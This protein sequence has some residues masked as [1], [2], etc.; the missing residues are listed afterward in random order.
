MVYTGSNDWLLLV[1]VALR[2]LSS[3]TGSASGSAA[4]SHDIGALSPTK[5][6]KPSVRFSDRGQTRTIPRRPAGVGRAGSVSGSSSHGVLFDDEGQPT[7]L[8][9]QL[10]ESLARHLSA[11]LPPKGGLVM[12]PAK[13]ATFYERYF[14]DPEPI[15]RI[16]ALFRADHDAAYAGLEKVYEVLGCEYH[17]VRDSSTPKSRPKLPAL[18][19]AGY[20]EFMTI[21]LLAFPDEEFRRLQRATSDI[22]ILTNP[23]PS[24]G[25]VG[26][27]P[28][29]LI[30]SLFPARHDVEAKK[31]YESTLAELS[32]CLL[33][34]AAPT[35]TQEPRRP[36]ITP[37]DPRRYVPEHIREEPKRAP[38]DSSRGTRH[39][40]S[41]SGPPS[42]EQQSRPSTNGTTFA[43]D[44]AF[45]NDGPPRS[46]PATPFP[47]SGHNAPQQLGDLV[48]SKDKTKA[49]NRPSLAIPPLAA[50]LMSFPALE[51]GSTTSSPTASRN[52]SPDVSRHGLP[53]AHPPPPPPL[54]SALVNRTQVTGLKEN[55][56]D[57]A[58]TAEVQRHRNNPSTLP[59][60]D[61]GPTWEEKLSRGGASSA[62]T[63]SSSS[64]TQ[65]R[66]SGY[67]LPSSSPASAGT[68]SRS[69]KRRDSIKS[70][71]KDR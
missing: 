47:A 64:H 22:P 54:K 46:A 71:R 11:E 13:M 18:T 31:A 26:Q 66:K 17:L 63:S 55:S 12:T 4:N 42:G 16:A 57:A 23:I 3:P 37:F 45:S 41:Y 6:P 5:P 60:Q 34:K 24:P 21:A 25:D 8:C 61:R 39:S 53:S 65:S 36:S 51:S 44:A 1:A 58:A 33:P 70:G 38:A 67:E 48:T 50:G 14:V 43:A 59:G 7:G 28:T 56:K 35:V 49:V 2:D 29:E 52:Q 40:V 32:K 62:A 10:F 20:S 15:P 69:D 68:S 27:L 9:S 19:P 30:R